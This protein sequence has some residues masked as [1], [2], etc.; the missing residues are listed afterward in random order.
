M[1]TPTAA[2]SVTL[3]LDPARLVVFDYGLLEQI[4]DR[5]GKTINAVAF[6]DFGAMAVTDTADTDAVMASMRKVSVKFVISFVT[7]CLGCE[8][9]ALASIV[10]AEKI[11]QVFNS[12]SVGFFEAVRQLNGIAS[13]DHPQTP[14]EPSPQANPSGV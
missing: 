14:A 4:E 6:D 2:P 9:A 11:S 10:P 3:D 13:I 12:L 5:M 7:A 1:P 8:R